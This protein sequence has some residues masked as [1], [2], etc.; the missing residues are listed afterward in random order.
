M[1]RDHPDFLTLQDEVD[2]E[3]EQILA[4]VENGE[5]NKG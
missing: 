4:L 3:R 5:N 1:I 2:K